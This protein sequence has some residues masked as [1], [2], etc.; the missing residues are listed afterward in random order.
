MF[1]AIV[2]K[3]VRYANPVLDGRGKE[4]FLDPSGKQLPRDE[5]GDLVVA[6]GVVATRKL[7]VIESESTDNP[8]TDEAGNVVEAGTEEALLR[9]VQSQF[10]GEE[11]VQVMRVLVRKT[12][13]VREL[14]GEELAAVR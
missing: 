7:E 11:N 12:E 13:T 14:T 10:D 6:P 2:H 9:K 3:K 1:T 8:L 4:I 5:K